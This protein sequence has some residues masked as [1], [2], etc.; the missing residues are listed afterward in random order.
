MWFENLNYSTISKVDWTIQDLIDA[1]KIKIEDLTSEKLQNLKV[2]IYNN[3]SY[4]KLRDEK[5]K[6]IWKVV[7]N[8]KELKFLWD[9]IIH[10]WKYFLH[11]ETSDWKKWYVSADY[12][13]ADISE[14]VW[15]VQEKEEK[16]DEVKTSP[17]TSTKSDENLAQANELNEN[18]ELAMKTTYEIQNWRI[19]LIWP[20]WQKKEFSSELR[21][22][23]K[24]KIK[25]YEQLLILNEV[26]EIWQSEASNV[27]NSMFW[28]D[29]RQDDEI[30]E[31]SIWEINDLFQEWFNKLLKQED[32]SSTINK[33]FE[34]I[35]LSENEEEII[36][37]SDMKKV[38]D[39]LL[40]TRLN[41]DQKLI[42]I[43]NLMRYEWLSWNSNTVKEK[44][45]YHL[46]AQDE[47]KDINTILEN[48][49]LVKL[50]NNSKK[51][52]LVKLWISEEIAQNIIE[53]YTKI[54]I[55][56]EKQKNE[57]YKELDLINSQ[58]K[59][60]WEKEIER[61]E[62]LKEINKNSILT[63]VKHTLIYSKIDKMSQ[64][65]TS[66][67]SYTWMYANMS[68]LWM[69]K[70]N[71]W[72]TIADN[73]IDLAI[74]IWSTTV[75]SFLSMWVWA[76]AARWALSAAKWGASA[77]RL[78]NWVNRLW[79]WAW[80]A[81]WAW[82]STVEW[83]AFY[84][85]TMATQSLIYWNWIDN[86]KNNATN[87]KEIIKS[88][89]F[90]WALR[91]FSK[92]MW[93]EKAIK[94][95]SIVPKEML[96]TRAVTSILTEAWIVTWTSVWLEIAFEWEW[97]FTIE[98]YLQAL[99][100]VSLMRWA[101]NSLKN[102]PKKSIPEKVIVSKTSEWLKL[103]EYKPFTKSKE[104]P[105]SK[106][107]PWSW[108]YKWVDW[109]FY[110]FHKGQYIKKS[111]NNPEL[112]PL[113][114]TIIMWEK[115]VW[116]TKEK[117]QFKQNLK[118]KLDWINKVKL[119][120]DITK[121]PELLK[122]IDKKF[123]TLPLGLNKPYSFSKWLIYKNKVSNWAVHQ[124]IDAIK[125]PYNVWKTAINTPLFSEQWLKNIFFANKDI[126][127][128]KWLLKIWWLA[129]V[130]TAFEEIYKLNT[131]ENYE[132]N[133]S[134]LDIAWDYV[135]NM[136]LWVLNSLIYEYLNDK[137]EFLPWE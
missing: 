113:H 44:L 76:I 132:I 5:W 71:D 106:E 72:H 81:K 128:W 19:F 65:W 22:E 45:T 58:R 114:D 130:P 21:E 129:I 137:V 133:L 32:I 134:V 12:V 93:T 33:I 10:N 15:I 11:I 117:I 103:I 124:T 91:A 31:K 27:I 40:N 112:K 25:K 108:F 131:Q 20:D 41:K 74:D 68:G 119:I 69:Q 57:Y 107:H 83:I 110:I 46:L 24:E 6:I 37:S 92:I 66:E 105:W 115:N 64:R 13:R 94:L 8:W 56:T 75:L 122:Y 101:H 136:Y 123:S 100:L 98:E 34:K 102:I 88:I 96:K 62:F 54:K 126:T 60:N 90:M 39:V 16:K 73:N 77:V 3:K 29:A 70:W 67:Y 79:R 87:W 104:F 120:Q 7:E 85:W 80:L 55:K 48:T 26:I 84:E 97:E 111:P 4:L 42:Q 30:I 82:A 23:D 125:T 109:E 52:E 49:E 61:D 118:R 89:A 35:N 9:K 47:F 63:L 38:K 95:T 17:T 36:W 1:E 135:S 28:K 43:Y 121:D 53:A 116:K 59:Q 99:V 18:Q 127:I 2:D 51:D 14:Q 86:W 78:T 50:I